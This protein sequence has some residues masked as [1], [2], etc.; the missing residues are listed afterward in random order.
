MRALVHQI[1]DALGRLLPRFPLDR[2]VVAFTS[3]HGD[4]AGHRGLAGKV[5]WIPFD[6]LIR[7]PL[8]LA[9][10]GITA[11]RKVA[12]VVQSCD[13]AV[14]LCEL[15]GAPLP[16]PIEDFDSLPLTPYL[17]DSTAPTGEDRAALFL[18][19]SGWPG[20]RL[21][22]MKLIAHPPSGSRVLFDL[23]RDPDES[24]DVSGDPAQR[25]TL[26]ALEE[27]VR[28]GLARGAPVEI[29][30]WSARTGS[31]VGPG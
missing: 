27:L 21:G 20:V 6:D 24:S 18:Y 17:G 1:D 3:D 7:V 2:T 30:E 13:L 31:A 25:D 14:T 23:D 5:P 12:S 10:P 15:A 11:G 26:G 22:S 28:T 16:A 19:N 9:G 8:V 29:A 4:Y